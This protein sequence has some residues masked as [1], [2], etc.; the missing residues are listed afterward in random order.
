[1]TIHHALFIDGAWIDSSGDAW[2]ALVTIRED[3]IVIKPYTDA[4]M[5]DFVQLSFAEFTAIAE[6]IALEGLYPIA[7]SQEGAT[8]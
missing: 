5:T 6:M 1:M 3:G 2:S 7:K 4:E 8:S